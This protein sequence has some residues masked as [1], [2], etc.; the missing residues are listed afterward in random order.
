MKNL[1]MAVHSPF[2]DPSWL[3]DMPSPYY[4]DTHH[5]FQRACRE[6]LDE[7]MNAYAIEWERQ[8]QVPSSLWTKFANANMLIPTLAAPLPLQWLKRLGMDIL[9]GGLKAEEFD[10]LHSYIYFDE[11]R[12]P[13]ILARMQIGKCAWLHE[14]RMRS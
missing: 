9:P 11:V 13:T 4:N 5:K 2:E 8:E 3:Q 6:F 7:N 1:A 14:V 10:D 12:K